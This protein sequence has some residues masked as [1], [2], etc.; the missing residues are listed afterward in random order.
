MSGPDKDK[1]LSE[2]LARLAIPAE[3]ADHIVRDIRAGDQLLEHAN[4]PTVPTGLINRVETALRSEL[5]ARR[6]KVA[7][8]TG[9]RWASR[10]A[11]AIVIGLLVAWATLSNK[12]A[13]NLGPPAQD[14]LVKAAYVQPSP[15]DD[16]VELWELALIQTDTVED[17]INDIAL[18]EM[19]WLWDQIDQDIENLSGK[20]LKHE[21]YS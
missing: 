11:A 2:L 14:Q 4:D 1:E 12:T 6:H 17:S 9:L 13:T 10:V 21:N 3:Q 18:T 16:E 7:A 15:F 19:L 20:E 5:A 8:L